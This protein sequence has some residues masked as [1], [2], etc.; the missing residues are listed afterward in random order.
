MKNAGLPIEHLLSYDKDTGVV[1]WLVDRQSTRAGDAAGWTNTHG[2]LCVSINNKEYRLHRIAWYLAN[3]SFPSKTIDHI[4]GIK[5][6][7]R[8]CNLRDVSQRVNNTNKSFHRSGRLVGAWMAKDRTRKVWRSAIG[9]SGKR[10]FLG[11]YETEREAHDAYMS[12]LQ[13]ISG[14]I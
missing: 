4:N 14:T 6:D 13:S 12:E 11:G 3:G 9:V 5:T 7:N 8:L 2:Y 1:Q 10:K